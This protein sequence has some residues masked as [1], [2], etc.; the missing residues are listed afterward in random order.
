MKNSEEAEFVNHDAFSNLFFLHMHPA[1]SQF[2]PPLVYNPATLWDSHQN[3]TLFSPFY[4][5]LGLESSFSVN[6]TASHSNGNDDSVIADEGMHTADNT[7]G[8]RKQPLP[9]T[10]RHGTW[11]PSCDK[12]ETEMKKVEASPGS[13]V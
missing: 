10:R 7:D 12:C 5:I 8:W 9:A 2:E 11:H 1:F 4:N 3:C 13:S 6:M